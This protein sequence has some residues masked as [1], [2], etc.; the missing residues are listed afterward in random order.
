MKNGWDNSLGHTLRTNRPF[1]PAA[2][3]SNGSATYFFASVPSFGVQKDISQLCL[4]AMFGKRNID[5]FLV[6]FASARL[7]ITE[8]TDYQPNESG[9]L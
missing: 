1:E 3:G 9:I 7:K 2:S 8:G 6:R 4:S 5:L